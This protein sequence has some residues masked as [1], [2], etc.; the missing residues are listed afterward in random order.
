[1]PE[2]NYIPY[3]S[4]EDLK[5]YF[6]DNFISDDRITYV[7]SKTGILSVKIA[8]M[9]LHT[10]VSELSYCLMYYDNNIF[11]P[12]Y[13]N[14]IWKL[15]ANTKSDYFAFWGF[16]LTNSVPTYNM[17]ESHAGFMINDGKLYCSVADGYTQQRVEIIGIDY[18][19][20]EN[21]R[22]E[23]NKFY[24]MPLPIVE[25]QLSLPRIFSAVRK[26]K[27]M[28]T[29]SNFPPENTMHY[30]VNYIKNEINEEKYLRFNRFI[31]KEVYA[32]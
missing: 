32:D 10:G 22:I 20:M 18:T 2:I 8:E 6:Y 25:Q 1:M 17:I 11:N 23:Y 4:A 29:L 28:S 7:A 21:Y 26:W 14:A 30:I 9:T 19:R 27:L 5:Y 3:E 12:L 15:R 31:Y 13:S 16:K 24:I